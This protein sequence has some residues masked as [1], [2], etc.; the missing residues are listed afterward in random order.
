VVA[1]ISSGLIVGAWG[2]ATLG[3]LGAILVA[4]VGGVVLLRRDPCSF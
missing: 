2:F 1:S 4:I 3:M